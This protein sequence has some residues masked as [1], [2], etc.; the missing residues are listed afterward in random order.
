M[1]LIIKW[2]SFFAWLQTWMVV[3]E[4][5]EGELGFS[6]QPLDNSEDNCDYKIFYILF[7]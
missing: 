1:I 6:K 2:Y 7:F 4:E 5:D 3:E